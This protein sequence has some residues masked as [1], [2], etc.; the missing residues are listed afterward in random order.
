M[1]SVDIDREAKRGTSQAVR[2]PG[3]SLIVPTV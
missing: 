2:A 1:A 3:S